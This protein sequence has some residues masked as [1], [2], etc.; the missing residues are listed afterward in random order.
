MNCIKKT[1]KY[2]DNFI[3]KSQHILMNWYLE[4][5]ISSESGMDKFLYLTLHIRSEKMC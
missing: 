3:L 5:N 2:K 1:N 4:P